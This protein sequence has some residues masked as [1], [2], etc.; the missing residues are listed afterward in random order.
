MSR[1]RANRKQEFLRK[2][3]FCCLCGGTI[4]ATTIEH[5]PPR[6]LFV[7]RQ[8]PG[9][10]SFPACDRCNG[11][12]KDADQIAALVTL[13]MGSATSSHVTDRYINK[14]LEAAAT[15]YPEM[16]K[17]ID[18]SVSLQYLRVNGLVREVFV[19]G[20]DRHIFYDW[21]D[22]WIAKLGLAFWYHHQSDVFPETG[23]ISVHWFT[24]ASIANNEIPDELFSA[25]KGFN[26]PFQGKIGN[27]HQF[28][29]KYGFTNDR[30][31]GS[32]LFSFHDSSAAVA[33]LTHNP[34]YVNRFRKI[35][36]LKTSPHT[37]IEFDSL[38]L[39]YIHPR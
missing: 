23:R 35:P 1:N 26:F 31:T 22:P 15:N 18:T 14:L 6:V 16:L 24:N 7:D 20:I 30:T 39:F 28:S 13:I 27:A 25:L 10:F 17:Y 29:Y 36:T 8:I 4:P 19:G 21:L 12:S 5:A 38:P 9:A 3:P 37:G 2:H 33:I 11:G 34:S 32:F